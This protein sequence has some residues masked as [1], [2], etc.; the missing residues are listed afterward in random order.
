M[1]VSVSHTAWCERRPQVPK[2]H[3]PT[4]SMHVGVSVCNANTHTGNELCSF[5]CILL[6]AALFGLACCRTLL[7]QFVGIR[8]ILLQK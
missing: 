5:N 3:T 6:P 1:A 2:G 8:N 7:L 4:Q